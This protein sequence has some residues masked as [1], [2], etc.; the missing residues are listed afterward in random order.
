[1][2]FNE[3]NSNTRTFPSWHAVTMDLP[4]GANWTEFTRFGCTSFPRVSR[5]SYVCAFQI[6]TVQSSLAVAIHSSSALHAAYLTTLE[7]P[8]SVARTCSVAVSST[9]DVLS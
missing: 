6:L 8:S 1:M 4:L 9:L 7:W 2:S 3:G 5:S